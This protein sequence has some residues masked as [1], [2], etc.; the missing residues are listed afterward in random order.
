MSTDVDN[1]LL[2]QIETTDA[3]LKNDW[4]DSYD[5]DDVVCQSLLIEKVIYKYK[6]KNEN[7][8]NIILDA[9]FY[10]KTK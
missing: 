1:S 5:L 3:I 6:D 4:G 7:S 9:L 2:F 10:L 8:S